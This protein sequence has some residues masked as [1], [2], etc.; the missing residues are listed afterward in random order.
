MSAYP[1]YDFKYGSKPDMSLKKTSMFFALRDKIGNVVHVPIQSV[2][3]QVP[4]E[5]SNDDAKAFSFT[6]SCNE[7]NPTT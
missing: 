7:L 5:V 3:K 6:L 2:T 4:N 1:F